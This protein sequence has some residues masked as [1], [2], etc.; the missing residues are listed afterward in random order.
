MSDGSLEAYNGAGGLSYMS[1]YSMSPP[2]NDQLDGHLDGYSVPSTPITTTFAFGASTADGSPI[3]APSCPT[4]FYMHNLTYLTGILDSKSFCTGH[5]EGPTQ[6]ASTLLPASASASALYPP[7]PVLRPDLELGEVAALCD[8]NGVSTSPSSAAASVC[9]HALT[10]H[11]CMAKLASALGSNPDVSAMLSHSNI[12]DLMGANRCI[13]AAALSALSCLCAF[14]N[15]QLINLLIYAAD[16][17]L[18]RYED[19]ARMSTAACGSLLCDIPYL[20]RYLMM[21]TEALSRSDKGWARNTF[22]P[23]GCHSAQ[24]Q[25]PG[26]L[27]GPPLPLADI[28][29]RTLAFKALLQ[30]TIT[31]A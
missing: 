6:P 30:N 22:D 28:S 9:R 20:E 1:P 23:D 31:F 15:V 27:F 24:Q 7:Q 4:G 19:V 16:S 21:L 14:T 3:A 2:M 13:L 8:G 29:A 17:V 10:G 18:A 26:L 11:T 5:S 25:H 12:A